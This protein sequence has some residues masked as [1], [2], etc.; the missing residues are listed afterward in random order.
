MSLVL[1]GY[2]RS[3]C[4]WR[5]RIALAHKGIAVEHHPVN[6]LQGEHRE[7]SF[8]A[9]TPATR[10]PV[11][12]DRGSDPVLRL[13][14]SMAILEWLEQRWP[15]PPLL[16]E[17][18]SARARVRQVALH[19]ASAIQPLQNVGLLAQL[20]EVGVD[21]RAFA[22]ARIAEGLTRLEAML[23]D[24]EGPFAC[25]PAPTFAD[26]CLVP[27]LYNARRFDVAL[28]CFPRL[29]AAEAACERLPAFVKAHPDQQPD[30]PRTAS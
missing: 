17:E 26:V 29:L 20:R 1:H 6:L 8:R 19:V 24:H 27:Q 16:P 9:L 18:P 3:S 5:V 4:S 11:L 22:A 15:K 2:W 10:V 28:D 7:D 30:R 14:E 25:G 12:E 21:A 23:T 13:S